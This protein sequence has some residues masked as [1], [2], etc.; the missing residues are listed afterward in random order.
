M[1]LLENKVK[2]MTLRIDDIKA[3]RSTI[4]ARMADKESKIIQ[5]KAEKAQLERNKILFMIE[6]RQIEY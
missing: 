3:I 5:M 1:Y 4:H 6:T 2:D